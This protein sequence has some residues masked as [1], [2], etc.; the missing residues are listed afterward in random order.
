MKQ[1]CIIN[2]FFVSNRKLVCTLAPS[3]PPQNVTV[4]PVSSTTILISWE[5]PAIEEQNGHIRSY[6]IIVS[7][8]VSQT[9]RTYA[10]RSEQTQLLVDM[11][12]PHRSYESSVAATTL[13]T[14]PYSHSLIATTNQDGKI[15]ITHY[16]SLLPLILHPVPSE[17]PP[18]V[19]VWAVGS[20]ALSVTWSPLQEDSQNGIVLHYSLELT[21][22]AT[23]RIITAATNET[24]VV[25]SSLHPHY[26]YEVTVAA[27][28]IIGTGS[29]SEGIVVLTY[30][31]G[32]MPPQGG[33]SNFNELC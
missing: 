1:V 26:E 14:G 33:E 31:D 23:G 27:A 5:P 17:A 12:H 9:Q 3:S 11:L 4:D 32:K 16:P 2:T 13:A 18:G 19:S 20:T 21:E 25:I 15:Q 10:V 29:F 24:S 28:T 6:S 7:D 8:T 22:I 30:S